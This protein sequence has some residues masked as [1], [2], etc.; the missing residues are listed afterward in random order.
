MRQR[1]L[2]AALAALLVLSGGGA[3]AGEA[4]DLSPVR[5]LVDAGA[6]ST[7]TDPASRAY[8]RLAKAFA[9]PAAGLA[10]DLGRLRSVAGACA[11]PLSG[12]AALRDALDD[13]LDAGGAAVRVRDAEVVGAAGGLASEPHRSSILGKAAR[14]RALQRAGEEKRFLG[15]DAAAAGLFRRSAASFDAAERAAARLLA[16]ETPKNP[17]FAV[18][19]SGRGGALLGVCGEP[20][21]DPRLFAVGAADA[22]GP[23]FLV[24]HPGA[25]GWVR[26]PVS[27]T[28]DLWWVTIV[29]GDGAWA[30]GSGGRVVR[31]DPA[32]GDLQDRSTGV[33]AVLYGTWGSGPSD[34]WAVGGD[35]LGAGPVP[36][37]LHWDG[38]SWT[39]VDPPAEAAGRILYKVWG[40]AADDV[41]AV[42]Q[43][44]I[45]LH[46]DG[47]GWT[48]AASGTSSVLLTVAG[49]DPVVAVGGGAS[50]V[51]VVRG[52]DGTFAPEAVTGAATGTG[53]QTGGPAK[54]LNGVFV[55]AVGAPLAVGY[56]GTVVRRGGAGWT[57]VPGVP[58]A[59][60][61]LH[62][63][64]MDGAGNAVMV[65]GKLSSL[66]E[67]QI[68]TYGRRPPLPST[69]ARRARFQDGV[70]DMI[71]L[72]CAHSGCHLPPFTSAGL[73]LESPAVIRASTVGV[74]STQS[75][76]LRVAPGRP[77]QSYL[78]HKLSGTH[79]TVGGSGERM[80]EVHDPGDEYLSA[81]EMDLVRAWI[82][83]GARD[84]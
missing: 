47:E 34:V 29:P 75:P 53:S 16:K 6:A 65:G 57:G 84:D 19:V 81:E 77:S 52:L 50:A 42:G 59:V 72:N 36:A 62:A 8:D 48:T 71:Y 63:V 79:S 2:P 22:D 18:P 64:W 54:A 14:A 4:L 46:F 55:P 58:S 21:E 27:A 26:V 82:L 74:P 66:T 32:T 73:G 37:L 68:V 70:A 67:G 44:G 24:L 10:A 78:W 15:L 1:L 39:P 45:L 25:E 11:G 40:T 60:R 23:Q 69:V 3:G 20:G 38:G 5:D 13:A 49:P 80:P 43:G 51:A 7:G 33:D 61:D 30:S 12:D 41:W 17:V 31:Y 9:G 56:A 28:G 83:D 76:L 35:P